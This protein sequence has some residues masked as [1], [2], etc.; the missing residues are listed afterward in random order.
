MLSNFLKSRHVSRGLTLVEMV[1]VMAIF[2]IV[3]MAVISLFIPAVKST[4]VQTQV[5]DVQS[6]LRLAINRLSE[7]L[8]TAGFL[9]G[10]E[11]P[12]IFESGTNDDPTDFTI[13][14]KTVGNDFGRVISG[15]STELTLSQASML[16][17]F[18]IG[19]N[20][21]LF[22]PIT[23][24]EIE[25]PAGE[26]PETNS[27]DRIHTVIDNTGGILTIDP[28]VS[29]GSVPAETVVL[30]VKDNAQPVLQT[31]RYRLIDDD[32]NGTADTLVRE[33]N[34]TPQRLARNVTSVNF[35]Y[36]YSASGRVNK[37]EVTLE[38]STVALGT[39]SY[40]DQSV[41]ALQSAVSLRNAF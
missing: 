9:I 6:N 18:P 33:V 16:E 38:G 19:S 12:I 3:M 1:M 27:A 14:S 8:L 5:T 29:S 21:R 10:A 37:V 15:S 17:S 40:A 7:D 36:D 22:E 24:L 30:R 2:S 28:A 11:A 23:A 35:G 39:E 41:R 25:L 4:A 34:G 31:I 32:G 26:D 13:Q 20:I